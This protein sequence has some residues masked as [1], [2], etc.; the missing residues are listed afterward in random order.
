MVDEVGD[1]GNLE[2]VLKQDKYMKNVYKLELGEDFETY[3]NGVCTGQ[4]KNPVPMV[5]DK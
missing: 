1:E 2:M 5:E 4:V 3:H